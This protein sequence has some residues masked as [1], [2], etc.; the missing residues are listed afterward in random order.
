MPRNADWAQPRRLTGAAIV[1]VFALHTT[2]DQVA[3]IFEPPLN[4]DCAGYRNVRTSA[5]ITQYA[6]VLEGYIRDYPGQFRNWHRFDSTA[7]EMAP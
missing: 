1:P 3:L 2:P 6:R 5:V 4:F 7:Q